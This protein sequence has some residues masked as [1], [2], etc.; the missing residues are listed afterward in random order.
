MAKTKVPENHTT[1][2]HP[3]VT[4]VTTVD[5]KRMCATDAAKRILEIAK[6]VPARGLQHYVDLNESNADLVFNRLEALHGELVQQAREAIQLRTGSMTI[7]RTKDGRPAPEFADANLLSA[8]IYYLRRYWDW[9][10]RTE[11][12]T[13]REHTRHRN[14]DRRPHRQRYAT[15]TE[16]FAR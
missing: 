4:L 3:A 8:A 12:G 15:F 2:G 11:N 1:C 5:G 9:K 13:K 6:F 16:S 10:Q 7:E 14:E